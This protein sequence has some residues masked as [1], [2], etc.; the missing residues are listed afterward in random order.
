[1][2]FYLANRIPRGQ[3]TQTLPEEAFTPAP[4]TNLDWNEGGQEAFT[5]GMIRQSWMLGMSPTM[6]SPIMFKDD[7]EYQFSEDVANEGYDPHIISQARS[8]NEAIYIRG[9]IDREM[10]SL[11]KIQ[12]S[13][14]GLAGE[15]TG[16]IAA[17]ENIIPGATGPRALTKTA[18][19]FGGIEVGRETVLHGQQVTRTIEESV[20][21]TAMVAGGT[22]ILGK[23]AQMLSKS[24]IESGLHV[25]P[26]T[27]EPMDEKAINSIT[28]ATG[29]V[30][31][32]RVVIDPKDGSM[33]GG[34]LAEALSIGPLARILKSSSGVAKETVQLIADNPFITKAM[35]QGET[36][37]ASI[38]ALSNTAQGRIANVIRNVDQQYTKQSGLSKIDF[39]TS[40]ADAL[41]AGGRHTNRFVQDASQEYKKVLDGLYDEMIELKMIKAPKDGGLPLGAEGYFP[42]IYNKAAVQQ[43][44]AT[45]QR[46]LMR[47]VKIEA[48]NANKQ[49]GD[50]QVQQ[51]ASDIM[52]NMMGGLPLGKSRPSSGLGSLQAR[53]IT[54]SDEMLSPYLEREASKVILNH[55]QQ[56]T[57]YIE[58][59][60]MF[61]GTDILDIGKLIRE[62]Y[63]KLFSEA[64]S[65]P[66][67][68]NKLRN[69]ETRV[70]EDLERIKD[71]ILHNQHKSSLS[72]ATQS[73]IRGIQAFNAAVQM[74]GVVLSSIPDIARP[75]AQYGLT[76]YVR[77]IGRVFKDMITGNMALNK[78]QANRMG[79]ALERQLN[80]KSMEI[81]DDTLGAPNKFA[82]WL[83]KQWPLRSGFLHYTDMMEGITAQIANDWVLTQAGK[84]AR[85]KT[86]SKTNTEQLARMGLDKAD[87]IKAWGEASR[88]GG[89]DSAL[90]FSNTLEWKDAEFAMRYEASVGS[91][92]RRT[93][94]RPG[95][96]D[97]PLSMDEPVMRLLF[98]YM[99]FLTA[100]TNRMVV[101][102]IQQRDLAM[103]GGLLLG[104]SM[105]GMVAGLKEIA[106]GG[107]PSDWSGDKWLREG[108]DRSGYSGIYNPGLN[109]AL[110]PF[111]EETSKYSQQTA[112]SLLGGPTI[113]QMG[114]AMNLYKAGVEGDTEKIGKAAMKM[115]PLINS[116]HMR[117]VMLR[118]GE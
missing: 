14:W 24:D 84:L 58:M 54:M 8:Q 29:T 20:T 7:D 19:L 52:D 1:M 61:D 44:F 51:V 63:Q 48:R 65:D 49:V 27:F 76:S 32:M 79:I 78:V 115:T 117:D 103:A 66:K 82:D 50:A 35:Q 105:G 97:K 68:L 101:A 87:L 91:D 45:L 18:A 57:P 46:Q 116:M 86:I 110:Q 69:E 42:R 114:N 95:A 64:K 31:A 62:D 13:S 38:E 98:Q 92:V 108:W 106:R 11:E 26:S 43:N 80:Q 36:A 102:G 72:T 40:V 47:M 112:K 3:E 96:G 60:K 9:Q 25:K 4:V 67:K 90:K 94:I 77:G 99:G 37:G 59:Q 70:L 71:R 30:G 74:G 89:T 23:A 75:L 10:A 93:I 2:G 21:N 73:A 55:V 104:V 109:L 5:E 39:E 83:G 100:A 16:A 41:S 81:M 113:S 56:I 111:N 6:S 33:T 118:L 15:V 17:V 22:L 34:W 53:V 88:V 28:N 85:G 12:S 107:D